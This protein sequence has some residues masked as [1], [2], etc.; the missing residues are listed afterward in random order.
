MLDGTDGL[1]AMM[2]GETGIEGDDDPVLE[3]EGD[4]ADDFVV[5]ADE[6]LLHPTDA[7][8]ATTWEVSEQDTAKIEAY[9]QSYGVE[10]WNS[11]AARAKNIRQG[12]M[13]MD[14]LRGQTDIVFRTAL[15]TLVYVTRTLIIR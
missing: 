10:K 2:E 14:N 12:V 15:S 9:K 3:N 5:D 13:Y 7:A 1:A 11:Q 6:T 4:D 8:A